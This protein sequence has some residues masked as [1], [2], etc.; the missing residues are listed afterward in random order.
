MGGQRGELRS[1][2]VQTA[3]TGRCEHCGELLTDGRRNKRFCNDACRGRGYRRHRRHRLLALAHAVAS[4]RPGARFDA[5][6][7]ELLKTVE[8]LN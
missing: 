5:A 4:E 7:R 8:S 3:S 6:V 2:A 1:D